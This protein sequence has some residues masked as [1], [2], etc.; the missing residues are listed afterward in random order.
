[1]AKIEDDMF[2]DEHGKG[3]VL[4]GVT[5]YSDS[6]WVAELA[7]R[8]GFE[9]VWIEMEHG[10]ADFK[11]VE[12]L[13]LAA[14]AGGAL[15]AVRVSENRRTYIL[16][17]LEV[18]AR[19]VIVPMVNTYD[20]AAQIVQ[21]GRFPPL[22][23]RGYN[24]RTRG[25]GYGLNGPTEAFAQAN[26]RTTLF[27]QIETLEAV[28][29]LPEICTVAGLDGVFIGPGDLSADMGCTGDLRN[30]ELIATVRKSIEIACS[31]NKHV[32]IL[33]SP[34]PLLDAALEAG[35]DFIFAGGDITNLAKVWKE[36]LVTLPRQ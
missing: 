8:I 16:R 23:A 4:R 10:P 26:A 27:A 32:G 2:T 28:K 29:N 9:T 35:C 19:I 13:C 11:Q 36:L 24:T 15:P 5:I 21:A 20:E 22:G 14:Q 25:V 31:Q 1:M 6:T 3:R 12:S 17:A 30:P 33:T 18:G 7:G 34:G